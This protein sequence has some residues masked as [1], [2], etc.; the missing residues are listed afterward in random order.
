MPAGRPELNATVTLANNP[1]NPFDA[2]LVSPQG[3]ALA[4]A[5]NEL[6]NSFSHTTSFTNEIGAQA[7]VL[8]PA[9]GAWTLIVLFAPQVSGTAIS[10]PF[11]VNTSESAVPASASGLPT[12]TSTKLKAGQPVTTNVTVKNTGSAPEAFFLDARQPTNTVLNLQALHGPDTTEPV[13]FNSN[14]PVYLVPSQTSSFIEQAST[15]G[16]TPIL[17]DSASPAGDPD[18]ASTAGTSATASL[19][20][21]PISQGLWDIAPEMV[22]A[23]G[24]TGGPS[25]PVTTSM[26]A[27]T[28][29]FDPTLTSPTGDVWEGSANT[30][31]LA[32]VNPV[33]VQPGQTGTIPVTVTPTGASGTT[34]SGTLYVDDANYILFQRQLAQNGNEVAAIPYAYS[35]K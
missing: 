13:T 16:S 6:P 35:V 27:T 5:A 21:N 25:E 9:Q 2:W 17:F 30:A 19:T 29:A 24:I 26:Q 14:V 11:T 15:T 20:A 31:Q 7:H 8:S 28:N 4:F 1:N 10:E 34:D 33:V 32:N 22:G 23:F 18:L 3:E 12:S